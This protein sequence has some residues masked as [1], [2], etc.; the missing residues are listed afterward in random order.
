VN[1]TRRASTITAFAGA[2]A[3]LTGAAALYW[4]LARP[5]LLRWGASDAEV[6]RA[7]PGDELVE[8]PSAR[9]V[10]AVTIE[11]PAAAVWPWIM[12]V[13]R[14]RGG[15]YSYTWLE[16]LIGAD[17]H[18]VHA[19]IPGLAERQVGDTVWMGPENKFGG[20][21]RM[22]VA[23]VIPGRAMVLVMPTD[24]DRVLNGGLARHGAW[25]FALDPVAERRTRLVMLSASA[26]QPS[27]RRRAADLL[28]WEPA[29]FIMERRMML[30]I[31]R[32]AEAQGSP[33]SPGE[34]ESR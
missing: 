9:G 8:R 15:F 11:A 34:P 28:F 32:L 6:A 33:A 2:T 27:R 20:Q 14:D 4:S 19:L 3:S 13:G 16:N 29:H 17:I 12:Q 7:W 23:K 25:S 21:A 26:S 1:Q 10:R 22:V 30:T 5:R 31:K 24:A 18:N